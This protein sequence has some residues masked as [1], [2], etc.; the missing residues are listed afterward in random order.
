MNCEQT[1]DSGSVPEESKPIPHGQSPSVHQH[2]WVYLMQLPFSKRTGEARQATVMATLL[3]SS[4]S[5]ETTPWWTLRYEVWD[6]CP[7]GKSND[8]QALASSQRA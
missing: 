6:H 7:V 8:A 1:P 5:S 2:F 3:S 4:T